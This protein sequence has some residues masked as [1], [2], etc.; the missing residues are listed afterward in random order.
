V[1]LGTLVQ[2]FFQSRFQDAARKHE[3]AIVEARTN[4]ELRD[5]TLARVRG[6][7]LELIEVALL[8]TP[9][10]LGYRLPIPTAETMGEREDRLAALAERTNALRAR[11][12]L[13]AD[14]KV[15]DQMLKGLI[16]V[17]SK[18]SLYEAA[19][20]EDRQYPDRYPPGEIQKLRQG[21]SDAFLELGRLCQEH[22]KSLELGG[23]P[24]NERRSQS[25]RTGHAVN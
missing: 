17:L 4:Q 9:L 3:L 20:G 7:Y 18:S 14:Q 10:D 16:G 22:I 12:S 24:A 15:N 11:L 8:Y 5:R 21:V 19:V 6:L 23:V 13:E 2:L 25:Q 1:F